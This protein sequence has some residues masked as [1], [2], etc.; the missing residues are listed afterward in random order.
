MP[1]KSK[2]IDTIKPRLPKLK[3][4]ARGV[5]SGD[6]V[7]EPPSQ[8]MLAS[9]AS[10]V[11]TRNQDVLVANFIKKNPEVPADEIELLSWVDDEGMHFKVR[12]N[13][14]EPVVQSLAEG[15]QA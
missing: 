4:M 3:P 10:E 7:S 5:A 15:A 14:V 1:K 2:P 9:M 12:H 6:K 8:S 11:M 13:K